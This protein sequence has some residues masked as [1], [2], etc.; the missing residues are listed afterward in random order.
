MSKIAIALA[1]LGVA[2]G[3]ATAEVLYQK[4]RKEEKTET[5]HLGNR[6]DYEKYRSN[7]MEDDNRPDYPFCFGYHA[8]HTYDTLLGKTVDTIREKQFEYKHRNDPKQSFNNNLLF[9]TFEGQPFG[10]TINNMKSNRSTNVLTI[11]YGNNRDK[12]NY[13]IT[14]IMQENGSA[15]IVDPSGDL[16]RILAPELIAKGY[17]VYLFDPTKSSPTVSNHYNPL[18]YVY[19]ENGEIDEVQIKILIDIYMKIVWEGKE[20]GGD[21]FWIKCEKA[22]LAALIYYVLENDDIP[23]EEK[24]FN[25]ILKKIQMAKVS[26]NDDEEYPLTQEMNAWFAK[27]DAAG[28][29]Y[30]TKLYYDEFLIANQKTANAIIINT[31]VDLQIFSVAHINHLTRTEVYY[32]EMNIDFKKICSQQAYLFVVMPTVSYRTYEFLYSSLFWQFYSTAYSVG[33]RICRGKYHIGYRKGLPVFDYFDSLEEAETFK[34]QAT[35]IESNYINDT[36]IYD[37]VWKSKNGVGYS[38]KTCFS[39]EAAEKYVKDLKDMPIWN[40]DDVGHG[41][42]ALPVHVNVFMNGLANCA[43]RY[44]Y[45]PNFLTILSTSRGYRIGTHCMIDSVIQLK[46]MFPDG[47]HETLLANVD[48]I[49]YFGSYNQPGADIELIQKLM[50]RTTIVNDIPQVTYLMTQ[51]AIDEIG[52]ANKDGDEDN[53]EIVMVRDVAPFICQKL[54]RLECKKTNFDIKPYFT[55]D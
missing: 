28:K 3:Y 37:I 21:P 30:K 17:P 42:P 31:L 43:G 46:K 40:G 45:I 16:F 32:P 6:K 26:D 35:V 10:L 53:R 24:C 13:I 50:G 41:D 52:N 8:Y 44:L 12:S 29:P 39:H 22:F 4:K 9:G 11:G 14:N 36:K 15:L 51:K 49:I 18:D 27:M 38:K 33:E 48:T 19:K 23:K 1:V 25:T 54:E 34:E 7:F 2:A 20:G 47:E 55:I 5:P